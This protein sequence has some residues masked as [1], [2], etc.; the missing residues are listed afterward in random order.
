MFRN[1]KIMIL[2]DPVGHRTHY[3]VVPTLHVDYTACIT[4]LSEMQVT[5]KSKHIASRNLWL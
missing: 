4:L 1:W 3:P 2:T 5:K